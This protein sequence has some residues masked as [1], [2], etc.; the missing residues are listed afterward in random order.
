MPLVPETKMADV[1]K[2]ISVWKL[3]VRKVTWF[4]LTT[5]SATFILS[6]DFEADCMT[7]ITYIYS[8]LSRTHSFLFRLT[9]TTRSLTLRLTETSHTFHF[10]FQRQH[11]LSLLHL[12]SSSQPHKMYT[13]SNYFLPCSTFTVGLAPASKTTTEISSNHRKKLTTSMGENTLKFC[14]NT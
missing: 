2:L 11:T 5:T 7:R 14:R 9:K 8:R 12:T 3:L 1:G 4:V 13:P 10:D 6:G